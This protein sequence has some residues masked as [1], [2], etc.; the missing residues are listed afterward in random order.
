MD[1]NSTGSPTFAIETKKIRN[2]NPIGAKSE[3]N[4]RNT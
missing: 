3:D 1:Q 4:Q 2:I